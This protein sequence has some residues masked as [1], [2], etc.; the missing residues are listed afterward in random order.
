MT[1][2]DEMLG[3]GQQ[4]QDVAGRRGGGDEKTRHTV[5]FLFQEA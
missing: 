5:F 2:I 3:N 4:G 1:A